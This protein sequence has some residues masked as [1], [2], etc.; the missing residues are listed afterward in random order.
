MLKKM[1]LWVLAL[2]AAGSLAACG[3]TVGGGSTEAAGTTAGAAQTAAEAASDSAE[4]NEGYKIGIMTTT[5]SQAEEEYRVAEELA[6]EYPDT[7]VHVTF[8]D[9]FATEMETTISTALSLAS[10]P[11]IKAII[12]TQSVSGTAAAIDKIRETRDDIFIWAG[13]PM[14]D[15]DVIA[16][17]ADVVFNTDFASAGIQDAQTL[18]ELGVKTV[19]HYS[20]PRHM[21]IATKLAY[22]DNLKSE[23]EKLGITFVDVTTPDPTSDAGTTGTQQFVLEDV[24]KKLEEYGEMTAFYGTNLAQTEPI[25]KTLADMQEGYYL[26]IKDPSPSF[27]ANPLGIEIPEEYTGDYDYL[28]QQ[29]VEKVAEKNMTGHF[30]GW[31]LSVTNMSLRGG[32]QYC[33]EYLEGQTAGKVDI[34]AL[35]EILTDLAGEGAQVSLYED[36]DNYFAVTA[37]NITY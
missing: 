16:A 37:P 15:N 20:F 2:F 24:P 28:S 8:P 30:T 1:T 22:H 13:L 17:A 10:D 11:D 34:E 14:D 31:P 29:I 7:I 33:M 35:R 23:S 26:I 32:V 25:I 18:S 21:A 6:E 27:Y 12:F 4:S 5:V 36:Y 9:N 19:V 3:S